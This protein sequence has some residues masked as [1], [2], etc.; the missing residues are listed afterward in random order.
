MSGRTRLVAVVALVTLVTAVCV[1]GVLAAPV[2]QT[3]RAGGVGATDRTAH[4]ALAHANLTVVSI[5]PVD[6]P[7]WPNQ[8]EHVDVTVE[9]RGYRRATER[10]T[11][12]ANNRNVGSTQVTVDARSQ[13]T[14]RVPV[15]FPSG[16]HLFVEAGHHDTE[17]AV[18]VPQSNISVGDV[19]LADDRI[20]A[21]ELATVTATVEN[22]GRA[23]GSA[24]VRFRAFAGVV[25]AKQVQLGA[26][27]SDSVTFTQ[28]FDAGG[29][30]RLAVE[31]RS[32]TVVV[33]DPDGDTTPAARSTDDATVTAEDVGPLE[34]TA[35]LVGAGVVCL[36]GILT[37]GRL[38]ARS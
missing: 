17:M 11:V 15:R 1:T 12:T 20:T 7:M 34:W 32:V 3:G 18:Q 36:L 4:A 16:G 23:S 37:V 28:R 19:S 2:D 22:T 30:Y 9:N 25:D 35:V 24:V 8:T 14:V 38:F 6:P 13:R 27:E 33:A 10:I 29:R 21:G 5:E 31:N 26:G